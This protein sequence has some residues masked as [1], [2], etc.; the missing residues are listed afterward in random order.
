[1]KYK[2]IVLIILFP[3]FALAQT[4]QQRETKTLDSVATKT[5][6]DLMEFWTLGIDS[7]SDAVDL[8]VFNNFKN[9][10]DSTATIDDDFNAVFKPLSAKDEQ[11]YKV[12]KKEKPFDEYAHDVTLQVSTILFDTI[13]KP[14]VNYTNAAA[15]T[16]TIKRRTTITKKGKY[17]LMDAEQYAS[18]LIES[19]TQIEYEGAN[20]QSD[21]I[22][23]RQ[24]LIDALTAAQNE[25]YK[26]TSTSTLKITMNYNKDTRSVKILSVK[27]LKTDTA[28]VCLN[29]SDFDAVIDANDLYNNKLNKGDFT[30]AGRP[31]YD[32][33]GV[34]DEVNDKSAIDKCKTTY[35]VA[36]NQGCPISY[37]FNHNAFEGFV[38]F[39]L[40]SVKVNLPEL[41]QLGYKDENGNDAMDILLSRKGKLSE[42]KLIFAINIGA[43]YDCY[44]GKR[45]RVGLST[46]FNYT[47]FSATYTVTDSIV[48]TF[49][50]FDSKD[51][52]RRR[53]TIKNGSQEDVTYSILNFPLYFNYRGKFDG[54]WTYQIS[55]GPSLMLF[56][57]TANPNTNIAFEGI[58]Q[59]NGDS[60]IYN[61]LFSSNPDYYNIYL[62][63]NAINH[64]DSI[65]G[66]GNVFEQLYVNST[67]YDFSSNENYQAK[68]KN[69]TRT[70]V[71]L[72]AKFDMIY[73]IP[74]VNY[75][76]RI[77]LKFCLQFAHAFLSEDSKAYMPINKT[78]DSY[79]SLYN[80]KA[81]GGYTSY[82]FNAGILYKF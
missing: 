21:S 77:A 28:L 59:T 19:R 3:V 12:E 1:M 79:N 2:I 73:N 23:C 36:R 29:D 46:G 75:K 66:A 67:N 72:N 55:L 10:F 34:P 76:D 13:G 11:P 41:N 71:A 37:F 74:T 8:R 9:L 57:N 52:Y 78:T 32:F 27:I 50:T 40:N 30:S 44:F 22:A 54:D 20:R 64:Q 25:L 14:E 51:Y 69:I 5:I 45:K 56:N 58:Y 48:Y 81:K 61:E 24:N 31:D 53:I 39:Q 18:S 43:Y 17:V 42:P 7:N 82:G 60:I 62:T 33:D 15:M 70:S 26:F 16:Y 38:G 68:Q 63:T 65:P 6:V 49:K 80:S 35:G 4:N 47:K